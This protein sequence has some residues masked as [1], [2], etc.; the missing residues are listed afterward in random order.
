MP[1]SIDRSESSPGRSPLRTYGLRTAIALTATGALAAPLVGIAAAQTGSLGSSG[2]SGPGVT[3]TPST[4][5]TAPTTTTTT[6][7]PSA[8]ATVELRVL[9]LDDGSP[10]VGAIADRLVAEGVEVDRRP[11][12]GAGITREMLADDTTRTAR[13]MGIV[14][15]QAARTGLSDVDDATLTQYAADYGVREVAA[16]SWPGADVGL[17]GPVYSGVVDG[18][19]ATLSQGATSGDWS[20]LD[21]PLTLDDL[22]PGVEESWGYVATPLADASFQPLLTTIAPTGA[23]GVL[24]GVHTGQDRERLILTIGMNRYQEHF[25]ALSHGIVS[26]LTRGVSTSLYRNMFSVHIDDVFLADDEWNADGNCT[27]ASDCDPETY[28]EDAPGASSRMTEEDVS[29]QT[30]W[31]D[32][33]GIE[34]DVTFNAKGAAPSDPLTVAL[35]A[36]KDRLRWINH[37]W[38]HTNLDSLSQADIESQIT[39]NIDWARE[40]GVRLDP[41][42]L[43]TGEHSGLRSGPSLADNPALA[44]ALDATGVEWIATDNSREQAQRG[45]GQALTVP[46]HPMNIYYNTST[47]PNAIDEYNWIYTSVADGGSGTCGTSTSTCIEPLDPVTGFDDYI[48][49]QEARFALGHALDMDPRPHYAH[50]SNLTNDRILYPV[51]RE[52]VDDYRGLFSDSAPLVNPSHAEAGEELRRRT[53][54]AAAASTVTASVKGTRL[55]ITNSGSADVEVPVTTPTGSDLDVSDEQAGYAGARSGWITVGAGESV[56]V[57]L[58]ADAGFRTPGESTE[59]PAAAARSLPRSTRSTGSPASERGT[60][61]LPPVNEAT[62]VGA[63][64]AGYHTVG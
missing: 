44:P 1:I 28:P 25:K 20:Y 42:E 45:V 3:T 8:E 9:V 29:F 39:R 40:S 31:E 23:S 13:Y 26:W 15:P 6:P 12:A 19:P 37:T 62:V 11:I 61:E 57:T 34:L 30:A 49:P 54:W 63:V 32:A 59:P 10:M 33:N 4:T 43:V 55:V 14:S 60:V 16:Y 47:V 24:M 56:T 53:A 58:P 2:S 22:S 50:Q 36:S 38:D 27:V 52:M 41:T 35:L 21:G 17:S 51:L 7:P 48:V 64:R 18:S 5:T 46:R